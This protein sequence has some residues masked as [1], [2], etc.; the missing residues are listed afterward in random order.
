MPHSSLRQYFA[1]RR[2]RRP[3][4]RRM[5]GGAVPS[6]T[7]CTRHFASAVDSRPGRRDCCCRF[8]ALRRLLGEFSSRTR[9]A[10]PGPVAC[11]QLSAVFASPQA[12]RTPGC[13]ALTLWLN[14]IPCHAVNRRG[15]L[16][17]TRRNIQRARRSRYPTRARHSGESRPALSWPLSKLKLPTF[18]VIERSLES[19]TARNLVHCVHRGGRASPQSPS[20]TETHRRLPLR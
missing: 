1:Q 2:R 15:G 6:G 17:R 20:P 8:R 11:R 14:Q 13:D 9:Q 7:R 16:Y 18:R 5:G 19:P 3:E 4:A 12:V 10:H